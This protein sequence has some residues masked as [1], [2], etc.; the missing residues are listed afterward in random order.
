[1]TF[2][3]LGQTQ[4]AV[5]PENLIPGVAFMSWCKYKPANSGGEQAAGLRPLLKRWSASRHKFHVA[6]EASDGPNFSCNC[7]NRIM[8]A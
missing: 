1:M 6:L 3:G 8:W 7:I 4:L 2:P 5:V